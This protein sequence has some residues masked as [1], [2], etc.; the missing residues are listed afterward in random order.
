MF[1]VMNAV[2]HLYEVKDGSLVLKK[3][4]T[5][6]EFKGMSIEDVVALGAIA[7]NVRAELGKRS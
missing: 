3:L 1:E 5:E 6:E 7:E 2:W 4:E